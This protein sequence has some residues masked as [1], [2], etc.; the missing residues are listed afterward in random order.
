MFVFLLLHS[1][2]S[3]YEHIQDERPLPKKMVY[4]YF[5]SFSKLPFL[6]L[7]SILEKNW[8]LLHKFNCALLHYTLQIIMFFTNWRLGQP[9]IVQVYWCH[10]SNS[11]FSISVSMSHFGN[12]QIFLMFSSLSLFWWFVINAVWYYYCNYIVV[13]W[14]ASI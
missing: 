2:C 9:Y 6:F 11:M 7:D 1:K 10:L 3:S 8:V 4:K 5:L 13:P 14:I 12:S